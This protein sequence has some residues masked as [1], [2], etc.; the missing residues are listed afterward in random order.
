MAASSVVHKCEQDTCLVSVFPREEG[1]IL[2]TCCM[3]AERKRENY[4]A[5]RLLIRLPVHKFAGCRVHS[6]Y[7]V[8]A[9]INRLECFRYSQCSRTGTYPLAPFVS[10]IVFFLA[11]TLCLLLLFNHLMNRVSF[12]LRGL[13]LLRPHCESIAPSVT[14]RGSNTSP[15]SWPGTPL[16]AILLIYHSS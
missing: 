1:S 15:P 2:S 13:F 16:A 11:A 14:H 4:A 8:L 7:A 10:S 9:T 12:C 3:M 5:P 6:F